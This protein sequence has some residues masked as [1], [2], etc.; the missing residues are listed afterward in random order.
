MMPRDPGRN[1]PAPSPDQQPVF[2]DGARSP[3][4]R[5]F[6]AFED[7]DTLELFSRILDGLI[8]KLSLQ[9]RHIDELIVGAGLAQTKN[10]NIARDSIINCGLSEHIHGYTISQGCSSSLQA[11]AQAMYATWAGRSKLT[12]AGGVEC[13]SD[14]PIVYSR[15]ARKFLTKLAK[16]KSATAKL[17]LLKHFRAAAWLP[18]SP[19]LAEPLTGLTMGQHAELMAQEHQISRQEQDNFARQSHLKALTAKEKGYLAQ[20]IIPIWASP[21]YEPTLEDDNVHRTNLSSEHFTS[22][23]P[24]FDQLFGSI[25]AGNS[26]PLTDGAS[27]GLLGSERQ[28]RELGLDPLLYLVDVDVVGVD[29]WKDLLT[30]QAVSIPRLLKRNGMTLQDID[31]FEIHEAFAAQVICTMQLMASKSFCEKTLGTSQPLGTIDPSSV[32]VNGGSIA[33][34]HPF[35]ATGI[36]LITTLAHELHRSDLELGIISACT[37]GGMAI[38]LLVRRA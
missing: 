30:G 22:F 24:E 20:E 25:T 8:N 37:A 1:T 4:V 11:I 15:E 36:R 5:S 29:P 17:N 19:I 34:G 31:R 18:K 9:E 7:C 27:V 28:A 26:A 23:K 2:I 16:A 32:N 6:G 13:L 14:V 3:F 12:L 10:P 38:S 35:G 21:K 33:I